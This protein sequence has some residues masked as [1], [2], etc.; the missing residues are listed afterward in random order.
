MS[1][2]IRN[3]RDNYLDE[4]RQ[5]TAV[6]ITNKSDYGGYKVLVELGVKLTKHDYL[7]EEDKD[8]GSEESLI[9]F[10]VYAGF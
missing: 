8:R 1:Y 5:T 4:D 9:F 3:L 6:S 10:S 2:R 7:R